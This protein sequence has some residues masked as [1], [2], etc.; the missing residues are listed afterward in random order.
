MTTKTPKARGRPRRFDLDEAV[1]T[2]QK[3][4]HSRGYDAV[5]VSDLTEVLG[6]NPPSFYAAF[7]S[8]IG[9]YTRAL[10]HWV[11]TS[12]IP[13]A[14]ILRDDRPVT[15]ALAALLDEAARR[16]VEDSSAAGCLVL[17]S[18]HCIDMD[19]GIHL[20]PSPHCRRACC[21]LC[22]HNHDRPFSKSALGPHP[23][24]T[25]RHCSDCKCC[26]RAGSPPLS[27]RRRR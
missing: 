13:L 9:L 20:G 18:M 17:E 21:R 2:A 19:P 27:C 15:E 7:G 23:R 8:K 22:Q 5:S 10:D 4:F 14:D 25:P 1:A 16:Y 11:A 6:I 26:N 3:L 24:T 12:A